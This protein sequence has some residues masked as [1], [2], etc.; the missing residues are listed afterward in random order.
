MTDDPIKNSFRN[1][2][3]IAWKHLGLPDPTPLQYDIAEYLQYGPKRLIIQAFRGVG[4][5]WITSAFVVW[6]LYTDPQLKFLVISASKQRADDFST[7]T[8]RIIS[9]MPLL[10]HLKAREDQRNSNVAFDVAPSRAAHAPSVK[11]VGITGQIVGS[12][13]DI[14]IADDVEVLANAL[15]QTMRDKLSETVKEFDAVVMPSTGRIVYLGTPQ[16]EESLYLTLQERGYECRIWPARIPT[17]RLIDFYQHRLSPYIKTLEKAIGE[18]T[19]PL[20]FDD[21]DLTE[22]EASYG[23]SGFA[24]QFMLDTS[25]E[26]AHR[27]PLKL[28]D[29]I[30][31]P[32]STEKA[33]GLVIWGN[34]PKEKLDL[35]AVGL[36]GDYFYKPFS[37]S[38]DYFEY[39]GSLLSIDPSGRG[40]D[41]TSYCVSKF[42]NGNMY[43]LDIGGF[44]GGYTRGTL[45]ALA[46][47]AR[48]HKVNWCEIEANFGD[49]MYTKI[50]EPVL[51][52]FWS[53]TCEEIKHHRQKEVRIIDTLEPMMNQH[54][55]IMNYS[56]IQKDYEDQ[57]DPRKQLCYQMTRLTKDRGSL[58]HDDRIDVLAMAANYWH[59]QVNA[60]QK[61]TYSKRRTQEIEDSIRGFM[62]DGLGLETPDQDLWVSGR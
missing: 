38:E 49:G 30:V 22:R 41:E 24:R 13:A 34:D 47:L 31:I 58:M 19:D 55:I 62:S 54:R 50:F 8:K 10:Q 3:Y 2:I 36:T 25:G 11:S 56:A 35:P 43:V 29:L 12:R 21:L 27:F 1:F 16:I 17:K 61:E 4:K 7:F 53:V 26:D 42:L 18:P 51:A 39:T 5:S 45:V 9:E 46:K 37:V 60:D 59:E 6:K 44:Q 14:I 15:T 28:H 32:L 57:E 23:K 40:A 52:E 20:R 48:D 33:P